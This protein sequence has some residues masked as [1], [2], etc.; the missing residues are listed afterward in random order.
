M[1]VSES[2]RQR[3]AEGPIIVAPGAF[4]GLSARILERVG[5]EAIYVSGG[6]I[7]RSLGVPDLGLVTMTEM[8][9]RMAIVCDATSLPVIADADTGY[10]SPLNVYR[11]VREWERVGVAALH[12]EDQVTPKRC[13][14]YSGKALIPI[15]EMV[16]KIRAAV[17]ARRQETVI[18]ARTDARGVDGFESAI[19]RA[20]AYREAGAD[21]LFVEAPET[22]EEV[23]TIPLRLPAP[24]MVNIFEGGRTPL[25]S[26]QDLNAMG[27]RIVIFPSDLQRAAIHGMVACATHLRREGSIAGFEP[28]AS[29]ADRELL[30]GAEHWNT[31]ESRYA[32]SEKTNSD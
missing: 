6:A 28:I 29:F 18:I 3:L 19:E 9:N 25:V 23:E 20:L 13:G 27:Y 7:S 24:T 2:L 5:F 17:D 30:V 22:L 31:L 26:S 21:V 16:Q 10:G 11:T 4:D 14:H 1:R 12:I 15:E 32:V 8:L